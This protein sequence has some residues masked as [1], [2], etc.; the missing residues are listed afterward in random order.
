MRTVA[1]SST[2]RARGTYQLPPEA[3]ER[4]S[5]WNF[6]S[7]R[8][9]S[10]AAIRAEIGRCVCMPECIADRGSLMPTSQRF[11]WTKSSAPRRT[12]PSGCMKNNCTK[13]DGASKT[14]SSLIEVSSIAFSSEVGTGSREENASKQNTRAPFRFNRNGKGSRCDQLRAGMPVAVIAHVGSG[15]RVIG[16][17]GLHAIRHA[18]VTA[19]RRR[20]RAV[21]IAVVIIAGTRSVVAGAVAL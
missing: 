21:I 7:D 9:K 3:T 14:P 19:G 2:T 12:K 6:R 8:I 18:I 17:I 1:S 5:P 4:N 10:L 15:T 20:N 11:D 16:A 13:K